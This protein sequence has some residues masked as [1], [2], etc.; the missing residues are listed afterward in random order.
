MI[1]RLEKNNFIQ[2]EIS[3]FGK[4]NYFSNHNSNYWK[5]VEY[6]GFGPS[7]H[8]FDGVSRQWNISNNN[9]YIKNVADKNEAYFEKEILSESDQFNE[10]IL[11]SLRTIW[12]ID[13]LVLKSKFNSEI[14]NSFNE[15]I[16]TSISSDMVSFTNNKYVLT[17]NGKLFAD[18]IASELF[19]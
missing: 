8:S 1:D 14:L 10:Y 4:E 18:K 16:K 11:T 6:I 17:S 7:A 3:N 12:G 13:I 5:G 19:V 2:Y 9:L 15:K